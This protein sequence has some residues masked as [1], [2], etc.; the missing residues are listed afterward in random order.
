[1]LRTVTTAAIQVLSLALPAAAQDFLT[2][3]YGDLDLSRSADVQLLNG[4]IQTA[5]LTA[6]TDLLNAPNFLFNQSWFME[7][8]HKKSALARAQIARLSS[9]KYRAIAS[10]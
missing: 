4:R 6:C 9:G 7:C 1:M 8:V 2:V 5:A 10:K 3:L